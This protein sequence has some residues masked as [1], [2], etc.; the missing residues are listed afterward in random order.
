[1]TDFPWPQE[2]TCAVCLTF[3]NLGNAYDLYRYGH[4]QGMASEGQY[5][6]KRGVPTI[7]KLLEKH[8]IRATFFIEGW[9][10]EHN[11]DLL[12]EIVQ[13][14]HEVATHG[15]LHEDWHKLTPDEE[16]RLLK[17]ATD[18]LTKATGICPMGW[19]SPAGFMT[20][21][22]I[23]YLQELGYFYDSSFVD[24]DFPYKM[25]GKEGQQ[26]LIQLPWA[27][28]LDD[29]V[30]YS[31]QRGGPQ[32]PSH[33][34]SIWKEEFDTLAADT[35]YFMLVCHPRFSGRLTRANALEKL[36]L[37]IKARGQIWFATCKEVAQWVAEH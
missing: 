25:P 6:V 19:R 21:H 9:N 5:A 24:D 3:D 1:M 37:H 31:H 20:P 2:A 17:L 15:Y 33:V 26:G 12:R 34:L 36:I 16:H 28:V 7:L 23:T 22:T 30:Y 29:A 4:A 27:W 32:A 10:G 35:G 11:A 14:G 13:R 8:D 18:N